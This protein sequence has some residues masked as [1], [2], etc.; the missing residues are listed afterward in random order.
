MIAGMLLGFGLLVMVLAV[1]ALEGRLRT[2]AALDVPALA[3]N[4]WMVG[5]RPS[6]PSSPR[7]AWTLVLLDG[8]S[9]VL[10][11]TDGRVV[12]M[13]PGAELHVEPGAAPALREAPATDE[14]RWLSIHDGGGAG[15]VAGTESIH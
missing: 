6:A 5:P 9:A 7:R 8:P 15:L 11:L 13:N 1:A 14:R 3:G 4:A 2:R 12:L 10:D